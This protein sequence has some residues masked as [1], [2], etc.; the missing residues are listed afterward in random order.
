MNLTTWIK[1]LMENRVKISF[2]CITQVIFHTLMVCLA[3][4]FRIFEWICF[5]RMIGTTALKNAPIFIIG[6]SRR[7]TTY[8]H[9]L[10]SLDR[11]LSYVSTL[12]AMAPEVFLGSRK[13]FELYY[14]K[15]LPE[16]RSMDDV[17]MAPEF[18]F[19]EEF[20]ISNLSP[21]SFYH[22][23]RFP[24]NMKNYYEKFVLF[25]GVGEK[26]IREWKKTYLYFLR[27]VTLQSGG[28]RLLL[29]SPLNTARL[30]L[31]LELFPDAK[32]IHIYRNPYDV[33]FSTKR[34]YQKQLAF[35]HFQ[36]VSEREIE[37]N[38]MVFYQKMFK[39]F[40]KEKDK[41]S[42]GNLI[43]VKYEDFIKDPLKELERIYQELGL[44]GFEEYQE[45]FINYI[46][47]QSNFETHEYH[48]EEHIKKKIYSNWKFTI[49]KWGY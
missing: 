25:D 38:I 39:K 27:K 35:F 45:A 11:N 48:I 5:N 1:L 22:G 16:T 8:L 15:K 29:K 23:F 46:A 41:V 37:D 47:S 42:K 12:Q 2:A 49:E 21:Y 9:S 33:Y 36:K 44:P 14:R 7:G 26:I 13:I 4:P 10:M 40:F 20:A 3:T 17:K 32:F 19:E 24:R 6:H 18:P 43:E 30:G 34:L 31:L 28:K